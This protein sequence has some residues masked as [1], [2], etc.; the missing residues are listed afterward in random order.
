MN[1]I[2]FLVK[3]YFLLTVIEFTRREKFTYHFGWEGGFYPNIRFLESEMEMLLL[4]EQDESY[5]H[6]IS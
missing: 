2:N 6:G 1:V 3:F 5:V 4:G